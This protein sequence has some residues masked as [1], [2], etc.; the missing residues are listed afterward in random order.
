M[1]WRETRGVTLASAAVLVL[2]LGGASDALAQ[3]TCARTTGYEAS[4]ADNLVRIAPVNFEKR[5]CPD[6]QGMLRQNVATLETVRIADT[7]DGVLA[8][9]QDAQGGSKYVDECVPPG[10]YR[11]GF[12]KPYLCQGASCNTF[13]FVD[14]TVSTPLSSSCVPLLSDA[15]TTLAAAPPWGSDN[16]IC[17][18]QGLTLDAGSDGSAPEVPF[19]AGTPST[20]KG[21]GGGPGTA[22]DEA[23]ARPKA[24]GCT[25]AIP[26]ARHVGLAALAML[27]AAAALVGRR[28]GDDP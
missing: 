21:A 23:G 18:Y 22:E 19:E 15:G 13:Y 11:Y 25:V 12:A 28:R 17:T 14:V 3:T 8:P 1:N 26:G 10:N 16:L 20:G 2:G 7:C 27:V 6:N 24:E 4:V 9:G 5:G